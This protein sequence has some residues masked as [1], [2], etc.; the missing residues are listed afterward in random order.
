M[1][2]KVFKLNLNWLYFSFARL[3]LKRFM[4][5]VDILSVFENCSVHYQEISYLGVIIP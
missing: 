5:V 3:F 4:S 2:P 1:A